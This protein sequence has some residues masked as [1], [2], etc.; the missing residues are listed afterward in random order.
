MHESPSSHGDRRP[1]EEARPFIL[2]A[3]I[4]LGA[5]LIYLSTWV[6][7][8][9]FYFYFQK[10]IEDGKISDGV[11]WSSPQAVAMAATS[12][13]SHRDHE[14]LRVP[15]PPGDLE[16]FEA[17]GKLLIAKFAEGQVSYQRFPSGFIS[18]LYR[19]ELERIGGELGPPVSDSALLRDIVTETPETYRFDW[20]A[21]ERT[22]Y[23]ARVLCKMLLWVDR[24]VRRLAMTETRAPDRACVL[25][26]YEDGSAKV[27]AVAGGGSLVVLLPKDAPA[28]WKESPGNWFPGKE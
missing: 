8:V 22:R 10:K 20:P 1:P 18:E 25:A 27:L 24:P 7:P 4:L 11:V 16:S 9:A 13:W 26:E 28:A 15:L 6:G 17:E 12:G 21:P 3:W 2:A 19:S 23:A 14:G 5:V